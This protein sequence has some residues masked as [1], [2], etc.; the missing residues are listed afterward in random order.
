ML[1]ISEEQVQN[2]MTMDVVVPAIREAYED[3]VKGEIYA[4]DRIFMPI[5]GEENVGQWL[6]ANCT[7]KPFF[8]SKFSSVFPENLNKGLPSVISKISLYSAETGELQALI[9]A[10]YLTAIKTG[11]SAA[12]ATDL[13]A[14]KSASKLGIIGSGLQAYSQVLAIQE[15]RELEE[16][17]IFD[18]APERVAGFIERIEKIKN[19]SYKIIV[20]AS[21]DECVSKSDIVCTCTTSLKPVFKG[22]SL[23]PGTH[24]NAIGS[25]TSFMQEI[26]EETVL[27]ADKVITEHIEGLWEAA[28]DI[29]IPFEKGSISKD[30]ITGTVGE[31]LTGK[32]TGRES[33]EEI[34]LNESVGSGVLDIALSIEVFN[35]LK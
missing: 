22:S 18:I 8:G 17:Y 16:V 21:G 4:G 27:R 34:T 11:G 6:F 24:V 23:K 10:N 25:F 12:I 14:K 31:V 7:N 33:D 1:Q 32:V 29:L 26:D 9:D 13:M 2:A 28:G 20:A 35:K 15:V 3:N 30:K 5:R 19:R